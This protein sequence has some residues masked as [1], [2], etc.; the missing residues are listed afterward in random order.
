MAIE[1]MRTGFYFPV[2][3]FVL[4]FS[5]VPVLTHGETAEKENYNRVL[6]AFSGNSAYLN[7]VSLEERPLLADFG[8]FRSSLLARNQY[9]AGVNRAQGTFVFAV[10]LDA[11]FAVDTALSLTSLLSQTDSTVNIF[12]AFLGG[13]RNTLPDDLF[14]YANTNI[15]SHSGLRDL[16]TLTDL[17]ENWV[18]CYFDA[19]EAPESL[20]LRQGGRGYLAPLDIIRPLPDLFRAFN[21]PWSFT[22]RFNSLYKLGLVEGPEALVIAWEEEVNS[23]VLSG[24]KSGYGKTLTPEI[25]AELMLNYA[26]SLNFPLLSP[27]RHYSFLSL[28]NGKFFFVTEGITVAMLLSI[29]AIILFIYL[30]YSTRNNAILVY[31]FRLFLKYF[32]FFLIPLPLLIICLKASSFTY[33]LIYN[34]FVHKIYSAPLTAAN[35]AGLG[36]SLT[37]AIVVFFLPLPAL[38]RIRFPQRA[39]F[40]G[41]ASVIFSALGILVAAYLD[42]AYVP[43]FIWAF[44]FISIGAIVSNYILIFIFA[45]S[46]PILAILAFLNILQTGST[47]LAELFILS[48]WQA[49]EGW[50]VAIYLALLILPVLLLYTRGI[51]L[52]QRSFKKSSIVMKIPNRKTR[53]IVLSSLAATLV[54]SMT[55][56]ILVFKNKNPA[57]ERLINEI[58]ETEGSG[59]VLTLLINDVVFQNSRILTMN[60]EA[61]GDPV[62]F[63]V[64]LESMSEKTLLPVYSAPVPFERTDGGKRIDFVLG[65]EPSNPFTMEIVLPLDFESF[66]KARAIY[67]DSPDY[68]LVVNKSISLE[69]TTETRR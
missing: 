16:L 33:H 17:P 52:F 48:P 64:S 5:Q 21:I 19:D 23:F 12:V 62:R 29:V 7:M 40:Y 67:N 38:N 65:E 45:F 4:I 3:A 68:F 14:A 18:L 56:Q 28:P 31:H 63:D 27:D 43:F 47:R 30:L 24:N 25:L 51:I 20:I 58:S 60:L 54:L 36:L 69:A 53:H 59:S 15:I 2:I 55:A 41:F 9:A 34:A 32:W 57:K 46:A 13:E 6:K 37:L 39:R 11:E 61:S 1:K 26:A 22:I 66:L 42:F 49:I 8:N 50:I 44:V 35:N 10:P